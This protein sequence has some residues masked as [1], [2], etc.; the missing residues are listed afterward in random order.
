MIDPQRG[1][2]VDVHAE[3]VKIALERGLSPAEAEEAAREYR[4]FL[5][6]LGRE[7]LR[8]AREARGTAAVT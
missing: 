2:Q 5:G 6:V 4:Y 7:A 8:Q 3:L 1:E